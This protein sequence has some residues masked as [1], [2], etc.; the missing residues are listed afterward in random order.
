[1]ILARS[2]PDLSAKFSQQTMNLRGSYE[3][4]VNK[5]VVNVE[6]LSSGHTIVKA[7]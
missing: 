7:E 3:S 5:H 2:V 4:Q 1:V 6:M